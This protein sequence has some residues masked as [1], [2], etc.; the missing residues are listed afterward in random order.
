MFVEPKPG[1][2]FDKVAPA[3]LV[4]RLIEML[5]GRDDQDRAKPQ[6][7]QQSTAT[8]APAPAQTESDHPS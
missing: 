6:A 2:G 5:F 4:R 1:S 8:P 7:Q 3:Y